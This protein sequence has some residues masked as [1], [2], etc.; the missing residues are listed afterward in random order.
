MS[1]KMDAATS[2]ALIDRLIEQRLP[3]ALAL[4]KR[5]DEGERL[6]E[7]DIAFLKQMLDDANRS[8][9]FV[10]QH[11]ELHSLAGRLVDL[12]GQIMRKALE[13]E[14]KGA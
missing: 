8:T 1:D 10:V 6:R 2:Q 14:Q 3:R 7:E 4:D 12:Y 5:M 9:S 11:P 13:N